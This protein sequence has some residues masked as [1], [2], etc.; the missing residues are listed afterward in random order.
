VLRLI[1]QVADSAHQ[2]GKW[3][4]VCGELAGDALAAPVLVGLGVDELSMN[5][6]G[7][8]RAKAIL[9]QIDLKDAQALAAKALELADAT[10]VRQLARQFAQEKL[11]E[12][13]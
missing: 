3:T 5:P 1:K 13:V 11:P 2:Y 9:R 4:G 8:P 6:G 10:Q 7:I 12:L